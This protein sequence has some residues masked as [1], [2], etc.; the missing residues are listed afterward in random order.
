RQQLVSEKL[1]KPER[2]RHVNFFFSELLPKFQNLNLMFSLQPEEVEDVVRAGTYMQLFFTLL[3]LTP[4]GQ[5]NVTTNSGCRNFDGTLDSDGILVDSG[6]LLCQRLMASALQ[7]QQSTQA[8]SS[9]EASSVLQQQK[10]HSHLLFLT[11][12]KE[13]IQR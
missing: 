2:R 10:Q 6:I 1:Q 9:Q 3:K 13:L 5:F 12:D 11:N 8:S 7:Q 4:G